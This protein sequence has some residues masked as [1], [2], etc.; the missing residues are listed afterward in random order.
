MT[1]G[2]A[3]GIAVIVPGAKPRVWGRRLRS[4]VRFRL[5]CTFLAMGHLTLPSSP[6]Q[7]RG[8]FGEPPWYDTESRR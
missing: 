6:C 5:R 8:A 7:G 4:A 1:A 3:P 2:G